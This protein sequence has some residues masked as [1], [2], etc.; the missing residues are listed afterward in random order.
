M[1]QE[2]P[3]CGGLVI[4]GQ[5]ET[6]RDETQEPACHEA[7]VLSD[8]SGRTAHQQHDVCLQWESRWCACL[9]RAW[10]RRQFAWLDG[11]LSVCVFVCCVGFLLPRLVLQEAVPDL[12]QSGVYEVHREGAE[13]DAGTL[14][15]KATLE[16]SHVPI[17]TVWTQISHSA[18]P[19]R[20]SPHMQGP[21]PIRMPG[22]QGLSLN[23]GHP[24]HS[25]LSGLTHH[26]ALCTHPRTA[27]SI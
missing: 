27:P 23:S 18:S 14:E 26:D 7:L 4:L 21:L 22:M 1:N 20:P 17:G 5:D 10:G 16:R 11:C 6:G 2:G 13:V 3:G 9:L 12:Q 8:L 24:G 15:W 25:G 19:P